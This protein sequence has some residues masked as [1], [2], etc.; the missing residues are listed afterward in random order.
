M[1]GN[2]GVLESFCNSG[3]QRHD[4]I[5]P[6]FEDSHTPAPFLHWSREAEF[7]LGFRFMDLLI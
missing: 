2:S 4:C 1:E 6:L 7:Y 3:P 5:E